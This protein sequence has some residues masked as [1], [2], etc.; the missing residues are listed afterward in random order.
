MGEMAVH[1]CANNL[2][3][4]KLWD[5][6][7]PT[8]HTL[9]ITYIAVQLLK[10]SNAVRKGNDLGGA[11]KGEVQRIEEKHKVLAL[12]KEITWGMGRR[13]RRRR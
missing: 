5:V 13:R 7:P 2:R 1:G 10:I 8:P 11:N 12:K 4:E 3:K 9:C 6:I